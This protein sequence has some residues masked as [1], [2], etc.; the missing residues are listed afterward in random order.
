MVSFMRDW[1]I[2]RMSEA[3]NEVFKKSSLVSLHGKTLL[4][5]QAHGLL[6]DL[7][8]TLLRQ[9]NSWQY[10]DAFFF[11]FNLFYIVVVRNQINHFLKSNYV[12]ITI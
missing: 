12:I 5:R 9:L 10:Y 4:F 7:T 1:N 8:H 3:W 2:R 11:F 6:K